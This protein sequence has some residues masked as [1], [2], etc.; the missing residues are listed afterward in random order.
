M[1]ELEQAY[2][3][4]EGIDQ[5][6]IDPSEVIFTLAAENI[7]NRLF[8]ADDNTRAWNKS[9]NTEY[10]M[11]QIQSMVADDYKR[12]AEKAR[13]YYRELVRIFEQRRTNI[14][15]TMRHEL[16]T[17]QSPELIKAEIERLK[18]VSVDIE[19][20]QRVFIKTVNPQN[21]VRYK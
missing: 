4:S 8:V 7:G 6:L 11:D 5:E 19:Q 3:S 14:L 18:T 10:Y 13:R 20:Y 21:I 12:S 17:T 15:K 9:E 16:N 2:D 1:L